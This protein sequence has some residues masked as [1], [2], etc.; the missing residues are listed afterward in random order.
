[1]NKWL[2]IFLM[3]II[4]C[5]GCVDKNKN[6]DPLEKE[7]SYESIQK[8]FN[9]FKTVLKKAHPSLYLYITE[10][11]LDHL[12]DSLYNNFS[13]NTKLGDFYNSLTHVIDEIGCSHSYVALSQEVVDSL[14]DRKYFFPYPVELIENK[15]LVNVAGWP[16]PQATE[17]RE[18]NGIPAQKIIRSL[19]PYN[20]VEG[21]HRKTQQKIAADEFSFQYYLRYGRQSSFKLKIIDTSGNEKEVEEPAITLGEFNIRNDKKYYVDNTDVDYDLAMHDKEQYA[22]MRI[23]TFNFTNA[24]KTAF[25][26]FCVNSF[27]LIHQKK[28]IK[29]LIIDLRENGGG[30][31]NCIFYLFSYLSKEPFRQYENVTSNIGTLPFAN[32]LD[33]NFAEE[34]EAD[35][36]SE[37]KS[38]FHYRGKGNYF[39]E[40]S[41]NYVWHPDNNKFSGNVYVIT[42]RNVLSAASYFA[43][44]VKNSKTGK[45]V[46]EETSGGSSSGNG[47]STLQYVLPNTGIKLYFPFAHL[48]YTFKDAQNN[49]RGVLPDYD[50]PDNFESFKKNIDRQL[51]FITDSL[52]KLPSRQ[53]PWIKITTQQ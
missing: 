12:F 9:V 47:F 5:A 4:V 7:F 34:N 1:M 51:F 38:D 6:A 2:L 43:L 14:Q 22:Y 13:E 52:I 21:F 25:E 16:L 40:D 27:D 42:N 8:D 31:L 32:Y 10:K 49:S 15:L 36:N 23:V 24:R 26:N 18:I 28:N 37:L 29:N 50:L 3:A 33:K 44:L 20:S 46:G 30:T 19:M 45:I 41:L 11:N 17:I 39:Y 48:I 53:L 35:L